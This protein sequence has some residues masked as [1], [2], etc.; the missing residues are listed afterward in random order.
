[1]AGDAPYSPRK[2]GAGS[3]NIA[4]ATSADAYLTAVGGGL[5]KVELGDDPA[6]S[7]SYTVKFEVH[8]LTDAALTYT[9]GGYTR[10]TAR[11][12][13]SSWAARMSTR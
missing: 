13:R 2:Q 4:A 7:G 1:M 9:V 3:V 10:R 8:N 6:R 5:P 11:R 12:S